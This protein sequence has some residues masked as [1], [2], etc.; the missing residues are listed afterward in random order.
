VTEGAKCQFSYSI[1]GTDFIKV[2]DVFE[3]EQGKW[4]GAK[5]GLFCVRTEQTNDSGYSDFDYFRVH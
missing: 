5:V 3:A 4:I 2:N 1:D